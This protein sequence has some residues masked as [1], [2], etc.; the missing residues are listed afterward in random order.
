M[1]FFDINDVEPS[2]L[3]PQ[4]LYKVKSLLS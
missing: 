3:L 2:V 1:A 4:G